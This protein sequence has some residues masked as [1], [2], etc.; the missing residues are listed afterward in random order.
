MIREV[1]AKELASKDLEE[2]RAFSGK[3]MAAAM[4]SG[5][6]SAARFV[7]LKEAR[8][9]ASSA[10]DA[11]AARKAVITLG[12]FYAID[13]TRML[14]GTMNLTQ[15]ATTNSEALAA[16]VQVCLNVTETSILADD[17]PSAIRSI[18]IALT[19]AEKTKN[20]LLIDRVK[21]RSRLLQAISLELDSVA[22]AREI[23]KRDPEDPEA[24]ARVGRF[25]CLYK[26][27]W[28]GGLPLI[29]K[30]AES[31]L[32]K[33]A[34]NDLAAAAD[35]HR[36]LAAGEDWW[37]LSSSQTWIARKN[38]QMRAAWWYRQVLA[39]QTGIHRTS[40]EKHIEAVELAALAEQNLVPGL[41]AE[42]FNGTEF[43]P[44]A[45]R[46][47]D[48]QINFDW[49][50]SAPDAAVGKDNFAIRWT[51]MIRPPVKGDYELLV[52]ANTGAR[53]WV[54][55]KLL[56]EKGDLAKSRNGARIT[57]RLNQPLHAF[58]AEFWDSSGAAH[59]KLFW[60]RPGAVKDEVIPA[61][62]FFREGLVEAP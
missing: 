60:R 41:T 38:L 35:G 47:V 19:A 56:L 7:L 22:K 1:Y 5:D 3:L 57:V 2:R 54:D 43:K 29:A 16:A 30:G 42:L 28:S 49:G 33:P 44:F 11:F 18:S 9:L 8:D 25:L 52:L 23:L 32:K 20:P 61:S 21:E 37:E 10:G 39:E 46:R 4:E 53:L 55:E 34:Q 58:R 48:E 6:D 24:C 45:K 17:Y 40:V 62:V 31:A 36:R 12:K 27:D 50:L 13:Q 51:G 14:L 59:M 15:A 26:G